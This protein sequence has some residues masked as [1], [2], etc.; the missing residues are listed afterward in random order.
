M[1]KQKAKLELERLVNEY[2]NDDNLKRNLLGLLN[3]NNYMPPA[4]R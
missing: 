2:I 4:G 1:N 3:Q